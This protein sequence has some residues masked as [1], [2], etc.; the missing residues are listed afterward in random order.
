MTSPEKPKPPKKVQ[1][2][3][4]GAGGKKKIAGT[5]KKKPVPPESVEPEVVE[6]V[7]KEK[8]APK[9][10][11]KRRDWKK[12]GAKLARKKEA[13]A[14]AIHSREKTSSE[15]A[16]GGISR[17]IGQESE[18]LTE[19][20][21]SLRMS[22]GRAGKG[23]ESASPGMFRLSVKFTIA[24][25]LTIGI[26]MA[27]VGYLIG[28]KSEDVIKAE[29]TRGGVRL[30][31]ALSSIH[32]EYYMELKKKWSVNDFR[33]FLDVFKAV[34]YIKRDEDDPEGD[35]PDLLY[36]IN[37]F[38]ENEA[39]NPEQY[40]PLKEPLKHLYRW[41]KPKREWETWIKK[42]TRHYP[43]DIDNPNPKSTDLIDVLIFC[44]EKKPTDD[45][46]LDDIIYGSLIWNASGGRVAVDPRS[47]WLEYKVTIG[48]GEAAVDQLFWKDTTIDGQ[49]ARAFKGDI[50]N[51]SG[52]RV[53]YVEVFIS[54]NKIQEASKA[55][56][57]DVIRYS[58][59]GIGLGIIVALLLSMVVTRPV[60]R[61]I[62][63]V[64]VVAQGE[65]DHRTK[66]TSTDEIGILARAFNN[67][68]R[69]LKMAVVE[70][71]EAERREK[72]AAH[73]MSIAQGIQAKLLPE[74]IPTIK[75]FDI[76]AFYRPCKDVSG[77]YY[78]F[79]IVDPSHIGIIVADVSGKGIPGALVMTMTRSLI[80]LA[81]P[82]N[83]SPA[84][85]LKQVNKVIT[86]DIK[87]G[88][89]V[90]V[91]YGI[92]NIKD[93]SMRMVSAGHNPATLYR[94]DSAKVELVNPKGMA[95]G[96]DKGPIFNKTLEE[97]EVRLNP[98]DRLTFYT[99][100]VV[101]AMSEEQ[102][103]YTEAALVDYTV[104]NPEEGSLDFINGLMDE[105]EEHRGSAPQHDDITIT[106]VRIV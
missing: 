97:T 1:P 84:M 93:R 21:G 100:G 10:P 30:T 96:F 82:G 13:A 37:K 86:K 68:T 53:G 24:I 41:E 16:S 106:T 17:R 35:K 105:L 58:F 14:T 12:A 95:V 56:L 43:N 51:A 3:R 94:A 27:L 59:F 9:V 80:R 85:T 48:D 15:T 28:K 79:I 89:F 61:L 87:R 49:Q 6:E 90:T 98:G 39:L 70:Q 103:E 83:L 57:N 81:A 44:V 74:S 52:A 22:G 91:M 18:K 101:E 8:V 54:L 26:V 64:N 67:M 40:E 66:A 38:E 46:P 104:N 65:L 5:Q 11:R 71:I 4:K 2:A 102:E 31:K 25:T 62:D 78:D 7:Q 33:T 92:M 42:L 76:E 34:K 55:L 45:A 72:E 20:D 88:M 75:G 19:E 99:D 63:D 60:R 69:N 32:S 36:L 77:D 29:I 23:T 73:E 50:K 47:G